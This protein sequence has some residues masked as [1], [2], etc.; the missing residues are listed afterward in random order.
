MAF[1]HTKITKLGV[2]M[3][4]NMFIDLLME[5]VVGCRYMKVYKIHIYTLHCHGFDVGNTKKKKKL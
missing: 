2:I 1:F 4:I 3:Y 5:N